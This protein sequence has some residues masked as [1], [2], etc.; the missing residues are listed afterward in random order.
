MFEFLIKT[1]SKC[2]AR[3]PLCEFNKNKR[4]RDGLGSMCRPC[5]NAHSKAYYHADRAAHQKRVKKNKI[6]LR[7]EHRMRIMAFLLAHPCVD[8]GEGDPVV[9]DFDHVRGQKRMDVTRMINGGYKWAVIAAEIE[10]CV[11]RCANCHRRKTA[12]EFGSYRLNGS[13]A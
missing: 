7:A 1:C 3:K 11:V 4:K 10:K 9:L 6:E 5:A 13:V 2:K 12:G 8:C